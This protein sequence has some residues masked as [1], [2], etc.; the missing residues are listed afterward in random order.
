MKSFVNEVTVTLFFEGAVHL[1]KVRDEQPTKLRATRQTGMGD[2]SGS[3]KTSVDVDIKRNNCSMDIHL[4]REQINALP[5]KAS[6]K[7][8]GIKSRNKKFW[9]TADHNKWKSLSLTEKAHLHA[10]DFQNDRGAVKYTLHHQ[11]N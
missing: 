5:S 9:S 6:L 2:F 8:V 11:Q 7:F 10:L 1:T 3:E 4:S